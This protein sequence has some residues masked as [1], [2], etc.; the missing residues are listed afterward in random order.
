MPLTIWWNDCCT[1]YLSLINC[2]SSTI[3]P[4]KNFCR[5]CT[6]KP[7]TRFKHFLA[8]ASCRIRCH[9]NQARE[10]ACL[11]PQ[12]VGTE[13]SSPCTV[14]LYLLSPFIWVGHSACPSRN[15]FYPRLGVF[16]PS[17]RASYKHACMHT[18]KCVQ[19]HIHPNSTPLSARKYA[20][21][22]RSGNSVQ[23]VFLSVCLSVIS[24]LLGNGTYCLEWFYI[25]FKGGFKYVWNTTIFYRPSR[26][27]TAEIIIMLL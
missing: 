1:L 3:L 24:G 13:V 2:D 19:V 12:P 14:R 15:N 20:P 4:P 26:Y 8:R 17:T 5:G 18:F 7:R 9:G 11:L 21:G 10:P 16:L 22:G 23:T 25:E 27:F 6:R